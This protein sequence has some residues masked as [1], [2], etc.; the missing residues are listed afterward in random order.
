MKILYLG[1]LFPGQT[2][3]MRMRALER[4]G[5]ELCGV[6]TS[7]PWSRASWATRQIQRRVHRGSV[8]NEINSRIVATAQAF[9]P[10][11]VWADKQEFF[12]AET[13]ATLRKLGARLIHF[14][15]DPYFT[16][17]WKRTSIMDE[18]IRE[19]DALVYCKKYEKKNYEALDKITVYMPLGY[20]DEVHRPV[21]DATQWMCDVGFLGGWEPRRERM[22]HSIAQTN[23]HLKFRGAYWDF[24]QDGKWTL[25]R[26]LVLNE[27]AAGEPVHIHQDRLLA[28]AHEGNEVYG[29]DYARALTGA[30]I[31]LGFLRTVCPDQHTTRTFEIPACG[32]LLLADRTEEHQEFFAEGQEAEFFSSSEELLE[33][34]KFYQSN[35]SARKRVAAWGHS[36]C[37]SGGY[38]YVHRLK[39]VLDRVVAPTNN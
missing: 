19:F 11:I 14:T 17:E 23:V 35:E 30:K 21:S 4:L 13:A 2:A 29:D 9:K 28:R 8:I 25:K 5:H 20:C 32:S 6:N 31:G 7:E 16:L 10:E 12:R 39:T 1:Q 36:R 33:K 38:A 18:A 26:Y 15:P 37:A 22:L 34:I 24:L 3:L 27:L